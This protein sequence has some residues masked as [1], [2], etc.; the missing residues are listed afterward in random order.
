MLAPQLIVLGEVCM[1]MIL[2]GLIG[3]ERK[4]AGKAAGMRTHA[5]LAGAAALFVG[6]ANALVQRLVESA[7]SGAV[8][9]DP[10]RIVEAI[11]TGVSF[12][13]G[14]MIF[15]H[16]E[17]DQVEGLTTAASLLFTGAIG[18]AVGLWQP[19]LAVGATLLALLALVLMG[20]EQRLSRK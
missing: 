19:V 4:S 8:Q 18:A 16:R 17:G 6:L 1:A 13:G 3:L 7:G 12:I 14:G 11:V 2:G 10:L 20:W 9:S 15:R 5:L